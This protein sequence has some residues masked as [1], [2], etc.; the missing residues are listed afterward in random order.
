MLK[1]AGGY[2]IVLQTFEK[3]DTSS[4]QCVRLLH[5]A[6]QAGDWDLCMEL[7]RFLM[8]LD[9]SGDT[10]REAMRKLESSPP[11]TPQLPKHTSSIILSP[12]PLSP[13]TARRL[14]DDSPSPQTGPSFS[15][16]SSLANSPP[17]SDSG[18]DREEKD[19]FSK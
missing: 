7:A 8:A 10:L 5:K 12:E 1:T 2:L 15:Q 13:Q 3:K 6:K 18:D 9:E 4:D 11:P 14:P 19:N 16:A 17:D